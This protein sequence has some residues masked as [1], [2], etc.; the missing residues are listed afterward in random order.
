MNAR[1]GSACATERDARAQRAA[2]RKKHEASRAR[3]R[4][5]RNATR[6]DAETVDRPAKMGGGTGVHAGCAQRVGRARCRERQRRMSQNEAGCGGSAQQVTEKGGGTAQR[7]REQ[8]KRGGGS[9]PDIP[10]RPFREECWELTPPCAQPTW[11]PPLRQQ[12]SLSCGPHGPLRACGASGPERHC[13]EV[14]A[15]RIRPRP[16][17]RRNR[18]P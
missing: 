4:L 18:P 13:W 10:V 12:V 17:L 16:S 2:R 7:R 6:R 5:R 1:C 15:R 11:A 14:S 8:R 9:S 3:T